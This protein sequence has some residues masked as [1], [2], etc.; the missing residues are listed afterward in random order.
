MLQIDFE[1]FVLVFSSILE[2]GGLQVLSTSCS[3]LENFF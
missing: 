3:I 1:L 2:R